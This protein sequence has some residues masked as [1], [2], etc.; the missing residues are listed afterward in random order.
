MEGS[1]RMGTYDVIPYEAHSRWHYR[2]LQV[3]EYRAGAAGVDYDSQAEN[4]NG[5][6]NEVD[7]LRAGLAHKEGMSE[8]SSKR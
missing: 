8:M 7:A 6:P 3:M 1:N 2:I 4:R 5:Y